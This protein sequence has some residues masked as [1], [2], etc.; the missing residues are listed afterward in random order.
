MNRNTWCMISGT[1]EL[2]LN[3]IA[4][5]GDL[6][7]IQG[8]FGKVYQELQEIQKRNYHLGNHII[9]VITNHYV[10]MLSPLTEIKITGKVQVQIDEMKLCIIYGNLLQNAIEGFYKKQLIGNM[11]G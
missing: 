5:L 2:C 7:E 3:K 8:Y 11:Q 9:D 6:A 1:G 4:E 10:K